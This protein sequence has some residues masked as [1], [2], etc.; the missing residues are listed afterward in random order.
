MPKSWI[1]W[2][3]GKGLREEKAK[4]FKNIQLVQSTFEF[5]YFY[6]INHFQ[7]NNNESNAQICTFFLHIL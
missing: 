6:L 5:L 1:G 3:G 7:I 2:K 4:A